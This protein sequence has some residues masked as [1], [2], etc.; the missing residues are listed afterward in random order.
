MDQNAWP[1]N[2]DVVQFTGITTFQDDDD[3]DIEL[4][5]PQ[6][7]DGE[8]IPDPEMPP[9]IT[10]S[11]PLGPA[12]LPLGQHDDFTTTLQPP[13]TIRRQSGYMRVMRVI[14]KSRGQQGT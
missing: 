1:H 3:D 2:D 7:L 6:D 9:G 5:G 14:R 11:P 8:V 4:E 10:S 13:A 12:D